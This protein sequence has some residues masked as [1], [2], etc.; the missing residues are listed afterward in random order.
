MTSEEATRD[1][2]HFAFG[3]NWADFARSIDQAAIAE[4]EA[5][6][7]KLLDRSD[8]A[9]ASFL[10]IG[11]GSGLH[12]LAALRLGASPVLAIDVDPQSVATA[13]S[14]LA[15]HAGGQAWTVR[16]QSILQAEPDMALFDIV[17]S[18][19]VLHHTGD[20]ALALRNATALVAPGGLFVCALYRRTLL[21]PFWVRE[22]RWYAFASP[23]SQARMHALYRGA[24]RLGLL[25]AGRN[26]RAH[27]A[28]Y[29]GR[30]GM[31]L[32]H[33]IHDWL[34]GHPY[35]SISAEEVGRLLADLGFAPVRSFTRKT[36]IGLLGSGCDEYVFRRVSEPA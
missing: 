21:D 2:G 24:L 14:V 13:T 4:A 17:Y 5:G 3:E 11:C 26:L 10:D 22:K 12:A 33:D 29:K 25:A 27:E 32:D 23:Q 6:L 20:L 36:S 9:G 34:G 16:R 7:L 15:H 19:G 31:S 30:R 18:W 28:G 1:E 8:L 35:E